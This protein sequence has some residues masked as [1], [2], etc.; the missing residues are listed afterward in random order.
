M[1]KNIFSFLVGMSCL[2]FSASLFAQAGE[3][4]HIGAQVV[5]PSYVEYANFYVNNANKEAIGKVFQ[6]KQSLGDF[7]TKA[8]P[9]P[10]FS[11]GQQKALE[12]Y[13][14]QFIGKSDLTTEQKA[15]VAFLFKGKTDLIEKL[16]NKL[17]NSKGL[18]P[19]LVGQS[20]FSD[21][22]KEPYNNTVEPHGQN[23]I[24]GRLTE[25]DQGLPG[26]PSPKF[27]GGVILKQ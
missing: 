18:D 15:Q 5:T 17:L 3:G 25:S 10:K 6:D 19:L 20:F 1:R 24:P 16:A 13:Y 27:S 8:F 14:S 12:N 21:K 22:F 9:S 26:G 2:T 7:M 23:R 11:A 4:G